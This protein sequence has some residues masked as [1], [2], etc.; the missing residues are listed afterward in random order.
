[1]ERIGNKVSYIR[2][3]LAK[4]SFVAAGLVV[5]SYLFAVLSVGNSYRTQGNA[6]LNAAAFALCSM[7][8][9]GSAI[10]YGVFSFFE[11]EKNYRIAKLCLAA[12]G[13]LML[14]WAAVIILAF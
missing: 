10:A 14:F 3:P 6:P 4:N 2:K 9:T 11:K 13:V 7:V 8:T 12:A 1:M 5:V